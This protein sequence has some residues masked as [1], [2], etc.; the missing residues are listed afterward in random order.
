MIQLKRAYEPA[1]AQ[2][3]Y[4]VLVERL[5]PRGLRKEDAKLDEWLKDVAPSNA[6]RKW[7]GHE[8]ERWPEFCERYLKELHSAPHPDLQELRR[9]ARSNRVTLVYGAR[10]QQHNSAVVLAGELRRRAPAKKQTA[11][12]RLR[13]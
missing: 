4:R 13:S 9:R 2:D 12:R 11:A 3:G 6:L 7:Y 8:E 5:W 10:D 1:Q